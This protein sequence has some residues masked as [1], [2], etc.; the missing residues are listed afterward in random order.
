MEAPLAQPINEALNV[1]AIENE[2]T[3]LWTA[4]AHETD[5]DGAIIRARVLNLLTFVLDEE[6]LRET[7]E[8]L[9]DVAAVHPCRALLMLAQAEKEDK[10]IEAF[11]SSRC[12]LSGG[13]GRR[14]LC[15]EQ[16]TMR[17][18][19]RY[20]EELPS[21]ALPLLV[22][23]LPA[24]LWWRAELNFE[25]L[26]F[27]NLARAVDHIII[28]SSSM[29]DI[30]KETLSLSSFLKRKRNAGLGLSDLN[31]ARITEWRSLVAAFFDSIE[32]RALLD[33]IVRVQID[34]TSDNDAIGPK[35][36]LMAGWLA[37]RLGWTVIG[38][39][40][41][42]FVLEKSGRKIV[43]AFNSFGPQKKKDE[44]AAIKLFVEDEKKTVLTIALS[45][46][47]RHL[48]SNISSGVKSAYVCADESETDMLI[49]E[50][51]I[52]HH[53]RTYEG[54]VFLAAELIQKK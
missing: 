31:W 4:N 37:S 47:G 23:D 43:V 39:D 52:L 6:M 3:A 12:H 34:F 32:H 51:E 20:A 30:K 21:A 2:L 41:E 17:A 35:A 28:D 53:D 14:H 54:A 44:L 7:D 13:A 38:K 18:S 29:L 10:D 11:V 16:V 40:E 22:P 9:F 15:I 1:Q 33:K 36:L 46:D 24:F 42:D 49:R 27:R 45:E 8:I 5:D 19:G 25:D 48:Q 26:N 50:L